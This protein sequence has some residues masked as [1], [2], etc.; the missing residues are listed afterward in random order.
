[1]PSVT[2][3]ILGLSGSNISKTLSHRGYS[4][5][6]KPGLSWEPRMSPNETE[7]GGMA[8]GHP[9]EHQAASLSNSLHSHINKPYKQIRMLSI[10]ELAVKSLRCRAVSVTPHGESSRLQK[11]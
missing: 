1:M 9:H 8:S 7:D 10:V 2:A 5:R 3:I 4:A 11:F 6:R